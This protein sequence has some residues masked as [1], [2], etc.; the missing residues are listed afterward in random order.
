ML[1]R[2]VITSM[3]I[4]VI[5]IIVIIAITITNVVMIT[6]IITITI[7]VTFKNI[8]IYSHNELNKPSCYYCHQCY[9][10][11]NQTQYS[12]TV[13]VHFIRLDTK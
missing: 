6:I 12:N 9:S 10:T 2:G 3:N 5:M 4:N 13:T 11:Q 8:Y 7:T 1:Q